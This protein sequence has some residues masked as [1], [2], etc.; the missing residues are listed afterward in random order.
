M[1]RPLPRPPADADL[2]VTVPRRPELGRRVTHPR[3]LAALGQQAMLAG[4]APVALELL[5]RAAAYAPDDAGTLLGLGRA[6][7]QVGDDEGALRS[8]GRA[9]RADPDNRLARLA[10]ARLLLERGS[11]EAALA[12]ASAL[13]ALSPGDPAARL[14]Q[15]RALVGLGRYSE[16]IRAFRTATGLGGAGAEGWEALGLAYLLL[17]RFALAGRAL[18]RGLR[19]APDDAAILALAG[20]L[21]LDAGAAWEAFATF[22]DAL[23]RNPDEDRALAGL[24]RVQLRRGEARA[25]LGLLPRSRA[26]LL[27]RPLLGLAAAE[28]W[29]AT[30]DARR[31]AELVGELLAGPL[32]AHLRLEAHFTLGEAW[33]RADRP[34]S[35]FA[36][37][38]HGNALRVEGFDPVAW[39]R[40]VEVARD[41]W[42]PEVFRL[43]G[44]QEG[45]GVPLLAVVAPP[46]SGGEVLGELLAPHP[47]VRV[48]D[49]R[50]ALAALAAGLPRRLG[51]AYPDCVTRMHWVRP[52]SLAAG[53]L[54]ALGIGRRADRLPVLVLHRD[55]VHLG[56]L[57]LLFPR[58][59]VVVLRRRGGRELGLFR[60]R[61]A[62]AEGSLALNLAETRRVLDDYER[63]FAHWRE[64]LPLPMMDLPYESL[65]ADP[66]GTLRDLLDFAGAPWDPAVSRG[67][68]RLREAAA[69]PHGPRSAEGWRRYERW[70]SGLV[71]A[72]GSP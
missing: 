25:A 61:R 10:R 12:E 72:P 60:A 45:S 1:A 17:G 5:G 47:R 34:A 65:A 9:L 4:Q 44:G 7:L 42:K 56:L 62:P 46:G 55:V 54:T 18:R 67:A 27:R 31:A 29:T 58:A 68:A 11:W 21:R 15:G 43:L 23:R 37:W 33:D 49:D 36:A 59:R 69:A 39:G 63:I 22:R 16:A 40:A 24:V 38:S 30:G 2:A 35:A 20:W 64:V 26:Q 71:H 53:L 52:A 70:M 3:A 28:C 48:A 13:V 6:S 32:P 66:E 14:A 50:E 41:F 19:A 51:L 57:A 8:F